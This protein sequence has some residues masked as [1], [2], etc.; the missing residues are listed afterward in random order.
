MAEQQSPVSQ[1]SSSSQANVSRLGGDQK[2]VACAR[3]GV[4]GFGIGNGI[5]IGLG[6]G[7]VMAFMAGKARQ[8]REQR[9]TVP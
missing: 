1:S 3:V 5:G 8:C 7:H 6:M 4:G 2:A 9:G